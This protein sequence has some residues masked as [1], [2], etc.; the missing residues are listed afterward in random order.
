MLKIGHRYL[1]M[2]LSY[3]FTGVVD[4]QSPGHATLSD[5]RVHL[6]DV[7]DLSEFDFNAGKLL[8]HGYIVPLPGT[9]IMPL[10]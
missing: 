4:A 7:G 6:G 9:G 10:E 1:F 3:F 5:A 2:T 8:K